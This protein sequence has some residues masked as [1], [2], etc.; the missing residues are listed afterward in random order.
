MNDKIAV[1]GAGIAGLT[2]ATRLQEKGIEVRVFDKGRGVGGRMSSRRTDWGYIDHGTQYFGLENDR[3][4]DF[5]ATYG[6]ILQPW[7]GRWGLWQD[8]KLQEDEVEKPRYVPTKAM[9]NLCKYLA[10]DV[11]VKLETRIIKL[12]KEDTWT[13]IDENNHHYTDF[14]TVILT[15]PV[16][17]SLALLPDNSPL[18]AQIDGLTMLP[19]YSLMVVPTHKINLPYDGIKFVHPVL[20]WLSVNDSKPL[21]HS[22]GALVIQS[23]FNFALDNLM[24]DSAVVTQQLIDSVEKIFNITLNNFLYQSLHLWRY[25][26][27]AQMNPQGYYYDDSCNLG[28]CAD[29]CANGRVEGAFLSADALAQHL[30]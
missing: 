17:Q 13:L 14:D 5:I 9:N 26:L 15:A 7:E 21:R 11:T 16:A 8:G 29:W 23:N 22:A 20:G 24:T 2:L 12:V 3:F 27:P 19:C 1:I 6:N 28:M 10:G 25:A 18:K 30:L 4:R